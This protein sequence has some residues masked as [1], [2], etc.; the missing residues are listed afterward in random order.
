MSQV[1]EIL[2]L[3]TI[4]DEAA[5]LRAALA[6]IDRRLQGDEELIAARHE[7]LEVESRLNAV[8]SRQRRLEDEVES[9]SDKLAREETRLYDGSVKVLKELQGLQAEVENLQKTRSSLEDELIGVLDEAEAID[10]EY[11]AK[12]AVVRKLEERWEQHS[13][14]LRREARRLTDAVVRV[15]ARREA[16]KTKISPRPLQ[17]YEDLRVRKGGMAVARVV[18][19]T[20]SG[21][22][23]AIPDAVRR[24]AMSPTDL[25]QCP[26]CERIL[27]IG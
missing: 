26:N 18:G 7:L 25:A 9:L 8:R 2:T 4:D 17:L 13:Q 22:R 27:S 14:D 20:C 5:S 24:K 6:D 19:A 21:C 23:V 12:A 10:R 16:Q 15:D 3:Q 1:L 11:A